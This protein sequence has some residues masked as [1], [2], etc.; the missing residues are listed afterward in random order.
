MRRFSLFACCLS[1][2]LCLAAACDRGSSNTQTKEPAQEASPETA[3]DQSRQQY[4]D[5]LLDAYSY[6]LMQVRYSQLAT[7][8]ASTPAVKSFAGQSANWHEALNEELAQMAAGENVSLPDT[9]GSDVEDYSEELAAL[10]AADFELRYLEVLQQIQQK[11]ISLYTST[12]ETA[13]DTTLRSWATQKVPDLEAH[14]QAVEELTDQ[15]KAQ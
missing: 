9:T 5:F 11:T 14:K 15:L 10:P 3:P 12:A 7:E 2:L 4:S 1:A 6:G 8:K 13:A